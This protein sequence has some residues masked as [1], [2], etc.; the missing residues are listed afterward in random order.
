MG[1]ILVVGLGPGDLAQLP[2]GVYQLLKKGLPIYL[3]T[4]LH[5]VVPALEAEGLDF[6]DF[7]Q[8]YEANK[9]FETVY[10]TIV[11]EL[12]TLVENSSTDI[13]YAVPGHPMVAEKS[14]QL[15]LENQVGITIEIKGGKSFLDDFFQAVKIDPVEGFQLLDALDLQQDQI[16]TSQHV[17]VMQVFNDYVASDVKLTLMEIYPDEHQVAL[18][19]SAG[20]Q[21]EV[22]EWLALY[23]ID[24]MEGVHNLTSLYVPPLELDQRIKSFATTQ[25]YA[26]AINGETGDIWVL[27]QTDKT[28]IPYL[29]EETAELMAAIENEDIDNI[30]EELGDVLMHVLYQT[31]YGERT[32]YFTFEDVLETLNRK[33]RRRHPHVFDG[34]KVDSIEEVDALWQKIKAEEKRNNQ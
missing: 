19:H 16:Q 25:T 29:Q 33:L 24:R 18:V 34:I 28:L 27:E 30:I 26:D 10:E 1:K 21:D 11:A 15:L 3:R 14:V 13:I 17:I 20:S 8:V 31:G 7:D 9:Q 6:Y 5:P 12:L 4:K 32:G 23:E 2:F 22:I